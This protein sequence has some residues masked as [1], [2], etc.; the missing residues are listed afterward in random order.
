MIESNH[1][2]SPNKEVATVHF[3]S[4]DG[5][6]AG[7]TQLYGNDEDMDT[8]AEGPPEQDQREE[9]PAD[10][11]VIAPPE[12]PPSEDQQG[13]GRIAKG[14][15]DPRAPTREQ[16]AEHELTHANFRDWC[17]ACVRGRG[18]AAAHR[19]QDEDEPSG[20]PAVHYDYCFMG[21][22]Q[23]DDGVD[24]EEETWVNSEEM[25]KILNVKLRSFR[26][27]R[28]HLV[29]KKGLSGQPWIAKRVAEDIKIWGCSDVVLKSDQERS[30]KAITNEAQTLRAP[31]VT[32]PEEAPRGDSQSN[33]IIERG[34]RSITEQIR[35]LIIALEDKLRCKIKAN[36]P[37]MYWLVEHAAFILTYFQVGTDGKTAYER[38]KGKPA[39]LE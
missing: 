14:V 11:P 34:N 24:V 16:R 1:A 2:I 17:S 3:P 6:G 30:L 4:G 35:T 23:K 12:L 27:L 19:K 20:V 13:E 18:I 15:R 36:H 31:M 38:H 33:G 32:I 8:N 29:P 9:Q 26:R 28:A 5:G 7:V 22:Q 39:K 37:V 25:M 10:A 21:D